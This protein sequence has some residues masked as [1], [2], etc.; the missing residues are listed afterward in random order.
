LHQTLGAKYLFA[1]CFSHY[2]AAARAA[3][4]CG[5][6]FSSALLFFALP[7]LAPYARRSPLRQKWLRGRKIL[8]LAAF[9][10]WACEEEDTETRLVLQAQI[11]LSGAKLHEFY[12]KKRDKLFRCSK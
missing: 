6:A 7:F 2:I 5:F 12:T 9:R 1:A 10:I 4:S 8:R 3:C 11:P